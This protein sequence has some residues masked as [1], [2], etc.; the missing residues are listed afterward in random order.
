VAPDPEASFAARYGLPGGRGEGRPMPP[1]RPVYAQPA[2]P[3][4]AAASRGGLPPALDEKQLKVT[5]TLCAVKLLPS[6]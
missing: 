4:A 6:K 1:P 2:A 3:A 5:L